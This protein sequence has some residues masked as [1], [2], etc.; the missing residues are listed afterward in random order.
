MAVTD[1]IADMLARITNAIRGGKTQVQMPASR[2]KQRLAE[3]L[4]DEGFL[5]GVTLDRDGRQGLLT[6]QLRWDGPRECAI[7][8]LRRVSR[9][10]R[11][12]Y[13]GRSA[14]PRVQSGLG[15]SILTTSRGI[16]TDRQ[17]RKVK[18]G[19]ELLCEVW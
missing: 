9:P 8:G 16:M 10:G 18:V 7:R 1:P 3:V 11:R 12:A 6:L 14:L 19:G 17:A 5:A 2:L 13:V 4:R 15:V